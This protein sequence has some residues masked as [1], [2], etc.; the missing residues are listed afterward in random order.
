MNT[1]SFLSGRNIGLDLL[2]AGLILEGVLL[3][4]SRSLPGEN[5]WYYVAQRDPSELF[6]AFLSMIHTFR[7]EVFFF[8]SGMFSALVV[9]RKG[10]QLFRDNRLKRVLAPLITAY[11]FLPPLMYVIAWQMKGT[12]LSLAGWLHSYS[13]MHHLWFLVSLSVMSLVIPLGFY[14]FAAKQLERFS[15]PWLLVTL[16]AL[17]N[18]CFFLKFLVKGQGEFIELIPVT[19]RFVVYYAAGYALYVNR[20][21]IATYVNSW[22]INTWVIAAMALITWLGFYVVAHHH[23]ASALK[24]L[25]VLAG[26]VLSFQLA[27]WLVFVFERMPVKE[28]PLLTGVVDSALVIYLLHYP[29]VITF[30]WLMDVWLPANLSIIYVLINCF[31]GIAFST[32]CYL[33]IKRS[34]IASVLFGLKVKTKKA[35]APVEVRL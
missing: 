29:V 9:L 35:V 18:V 11:L 31:I 19:A 16:I 28:N 5:G 17:A 21:K 12:P 6:T 2:R 3:H 13:M 10:Q 22:V 34:R 20:E 27:Y 4:A 14:Q 1:P 30:S 25:P 32:L 26:G 15:L 24:Y 23:I 7:M 33:L 8:L